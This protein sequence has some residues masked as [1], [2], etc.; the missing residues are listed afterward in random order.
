MEK[1]TDTAIT[2][3]DGIRLARQRAVVLRLAL[4]SLPV[5][6]AAGILDELVALAEAADDLLHVLDLTADIHARSAVQTGF[7]G[8]LEAGPVFKSEIN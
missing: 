2:T 8:L 3:G 4:R 7:A 6:Q 1:L 5:D